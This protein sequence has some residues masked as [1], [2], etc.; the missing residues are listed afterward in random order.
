[1]ATKD[2]IDEFIKAEVRAMVG[3]GATVYD[4]LEA[5]RLDAEEKFGIELNFVDEENDEQDS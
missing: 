5:A 4:A 3:R 2:E 1:M